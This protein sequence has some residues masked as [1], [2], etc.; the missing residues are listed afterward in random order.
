M[1]STGMEESNQNGITSNQSFRY[2]KLSSLGI[3]HTIE[4]R[5]TQLI[6]NLSE[7]RLVELTIESISIIPCSR[8]IIL[9]TSDLE[10]VREKIPTWLCDLL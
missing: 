3:K 10:V 4:K 1:Q 6:V 7:E 5:C 9:C 8:I 2:R